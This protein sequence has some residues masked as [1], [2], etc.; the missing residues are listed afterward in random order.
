LPARAGISANQNAFLTV[1]DDVIVVSKDKRD[2]ERVCLALTQAVETK[3]LDALKEWEKTLK[4]AGLLHLTSA[5]IDRVV[6][7]SFADK[8]R[9]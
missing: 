8:R 9:R 1:A 3:K 5:E 6:D 4:D 2:S 7:E